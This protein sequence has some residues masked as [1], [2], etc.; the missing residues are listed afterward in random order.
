MFREQI[1]PGI[2]NQFQGAGQRGSSRQGIAEGLAAD[3]SFDNFLQQSNAL[4][5][6]AYGQQQQA[7]TD[8]YGMGMQGANQAYGNVGQSLGMQGNLANQ[9]GQTQLAASANPFMI[10]SQVIGQPNVL[11]QAFGMDTST[12][13]S[14]SR[15]TGSSMGMNMGFI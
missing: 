6:G 3:R 7:A 11:N 15:G 1:M 5:F 13:Q 4:R 2:G 8:L 14:T 10:G 12:S 9:F